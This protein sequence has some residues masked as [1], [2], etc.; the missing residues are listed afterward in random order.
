MSNPGAP[1]FNQAEY[2]LETARSMPEA[3]RLVYVLFCCQQSVEKSLKGM[4]AQRTGKAPPR[5]H[6]LLRPAKTSDIVL[7]AAQEQFMRELSAY[8]VQ[9]RYPDEMDIANEFTLENAAEVL[10]RT[11]EFIKC[12]PS[13]E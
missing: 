5:T 10:R 2:D 7:K 12:L 1:W 11:E 4:I 9:S 3:G 13:T 8:Y 6:N